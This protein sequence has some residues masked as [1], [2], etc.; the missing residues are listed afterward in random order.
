M[1]KKISSVKDSTFQL[2]LLVCTFLL[3]KEHL[4]G[5]SKNTTRIPYTF[6][7]Y[8]IVLRVSLEILNAKRKEY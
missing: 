5:N 1:L 7:K 2:L 4:K 3:Y 8:R 6:V